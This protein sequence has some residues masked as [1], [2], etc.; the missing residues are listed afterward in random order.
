MIFV[1]LLKSSAGPKQRA[2]KQEKSTRDCGGRQRSTLEVRRNTSVV[3]S[4]A[5]DA[6]ATSSPTRLLF[7]AK[8]NQGLGASLWYL[9]VGAQSVTL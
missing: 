6:L 3:L 1:Q 8:K 2:Q 7:F 4:T 5:A 9:K